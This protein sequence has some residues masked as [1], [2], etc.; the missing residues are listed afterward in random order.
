MRKDETIEYFG[1]IAELARA[2]GQTRRSIELW[3]EMVPT[4]RRGK[5]RDAMRKRADDMEREAREIRRA[6]Y[7]K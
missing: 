4:C 5:V 2:I 6:S 3:P 1:S 7:E